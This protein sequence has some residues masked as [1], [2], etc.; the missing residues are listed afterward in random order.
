MIYNPQDIHKYIPIDKYDFFCINHQNENFSA[1]CKTC[2]ED[3][4]YLCLRE[5][6]HENHMV[7]LY[8]KIYNEKK[9]GRIL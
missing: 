8:N 5:K 1:Y 7:L 9:N 6:L 4:C 3:I 2:K